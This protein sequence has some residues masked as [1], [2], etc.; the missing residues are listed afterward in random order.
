[1]ILFSIYKFHQSQHNFIFK[2]I[3]LA[4]TYFQRKSEVQYKKVRWG[5]IKHIGW[6][7]FFKEA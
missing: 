1:M 5:K 3:C 4:Q 7:L 6:G 2:T